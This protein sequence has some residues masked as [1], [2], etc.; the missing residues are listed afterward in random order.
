MK[1]ARLRVVELLLRTV[2]DAVV[3]TLLLRDSTGATPLHSAILQGY[4][5]IVSLLVSTGFPETLYLEN[6]VGSTPMEIARLQFLT[7][8]LRGLVSR[9][10]EPTGFSVKGIDFLDLRQP[11]GMRDRDEKEVKSL[12]RVIDGIKSSGVLATKPGLLKILSDF[13][14]R[15][16]QEFATWVGRKPKDEVSSINPTANN[17]MDVCDVKATFDVLSRAVVEVHQR[18]LVS[19]RDVQLAVLAAVES[20]N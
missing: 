15:S 12:R 3:P 6:G 7:L 19:S 13:A 10:A 17:G 14:D 8:S 1:K 5:K 20:S 11:S 16:E 9:I 4:S 18:Q 2:K